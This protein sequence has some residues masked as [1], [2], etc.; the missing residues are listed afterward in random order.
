MPPTQSYLAPANY[1]FA[2]HALYMII[3]VL[4]ALFN[5]LNLMYWLRFLHLRPASYLY[6]FNWLVRPC[7]HAQ[8]SV[9]LYL[10]DLSLKAF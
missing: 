8:V 7:H 9:L 1:L 6:L 5:V 4:L 10:A 2:F 3:V